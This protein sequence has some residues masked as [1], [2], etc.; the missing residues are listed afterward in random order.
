ME[1][2]NQVICIKTDGKVLKYLEIYTVKKVTKDG[3]YL[4][5]E[6]SPPKPHNCFDKNRFAD[7]DSI[8]INELTEVLTIEKEKT[9]AL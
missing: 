1:N 8:D 4:L 7:F 3:H 6:V 2:T 5:E 9:E